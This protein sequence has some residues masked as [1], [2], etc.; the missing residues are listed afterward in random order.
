M[1][2]S[3]GIKQ[4][5][6]SRLT[7][8]S[9]VIGIVLGT[10]NKMCGPMIYVIRIRY[11]VLKA[12]YYNIIRFHESGRDLTALNI[13]SPT[14]NKIYW[15]HQEGPQFA[16]VMNTKGE[17]FAVESLFMVLIFTAAKNDKQ[18]DSKVVKYEKS[19][20]MRRRGY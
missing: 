18:S 13:K 19:G 6:G 2:V 16:N 4:I 8:T 20:N 5:N 7:A 1:L 11:L 10:K 12:R 9:L 17:S 15:S 14:I 3:Q